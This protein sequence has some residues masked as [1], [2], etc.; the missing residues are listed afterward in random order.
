MEVLK[1]I[2]S[3]LIFVSIILNMFNIAIAE[4]EVPLYIDD[5]LMEDSLKPLL[6]DGR[7]I[8]PLR[9]ITEF[10]GGE[11]D[12]DNTTKTVTINSNDNL[13]KLTINSSTIVKNG[14][15]IVL[16]ATPKLV[17]SRTFVPLRFIAELLDCQVHWDKEIESVKIM[18]PVENPSDNPT[19]KKA[20]LIE[21]SK[22]RRADDYA[23][24]LDISKDIKY[25]TTTLSNPA[26]YVIDLID[27]EFAI[28]NSKLDN[29]GVFT[30]DNFGG[31]YIK[32]V[33]ASQFETNPLTSRVVLDLTG[34][35]GYPHIKWIDENLVVYYTN[36]LN[37]DE[38]VLPENP[39]ENQPPEETDKGE[40][41]EGKDL[42][43]GL[44]N[45]PIM[46]NTAKSINYF[47]EGIVEEEEDIFGYISGNRVNVRNESSTDKDSSIVATLDRGTK[48]RVTGQASGWY[49]VSY[50]NQGVWV[51]DKYFSVEI[52]MKRNNVNVRKGPSINYQVVETIPSGS[53]V[54]VSERQPDWVKVTTEN[55]NE[56]YIVDYLV[57]LNERLL[58]G[59][60][61]G[62][63]VAKEFRI[64]LEDI[65]KED[66]S[67]SKL[68]K[69]VN[70]SKIS[71]QGKDTIVEISLDQPI[72]YRHQKVAGGI[73]LDL[74][75]ILEDIKVTESSGKVVVDM[76]FDAPTKFIIYQNQLKGNLVLDFLYASAKNEQSYNLEG[77]IASK[78]TTINKVD[79][80][81]VST[82]LGDIGTYKLN[83]T[84]Y[85][86]HVR[87]EL[88]SSSLD[89][90]VIVLDPGHGGRDPGA[91]YVGYKESDI[92]LEISLK[93]RDKLRAKG[94]TVLMTRDT[95]KYV[96]LGERTNY[97][98][99]M[100]ADIAISVHINSTIS[101]A[102]SGVET[103]YYDK[104]EDKRLARVLQGA[105]VSSTG[106]PNRGI[107]NRQKIFF[108]KNTLMPSALLEIG[109]IRNPSDR[110][111]ITSN[112]GQE[113]ITNHIVAAIES[114]FL[115]Q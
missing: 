90:K 32:S 16:D 82:T 34:K 63:N 8:A 1:K 70:Q 6:K 81:E 65:E 46:L 40:E 66:V 60:N 52:I 58:D 107:V 101:S 33:R 97:A 114:F 110:A 53:L 106:F 3:M 112:A 39:D 18:T 79:S 9:V 42:E 31:E 62:A 2:F 75:S 96:S 76:Y 91:N 94:V 99:E 44:T 24:F 28:D 93:I 87:L 41:E 12:W 47:V 29:S 73:Q 26:R 71:A 45:Y 104:P 61:Q 30:L 89:D 23:L 48:L 11:V 95:D 69:I 50:N 84:G 17:E 100:N 57:G 13:A 49:Q 102:V 21:V 98:N 22:M 83:T 92:A 19:N 5:K 68:P 38:I 36:D 59:V 85:S 64:T 37:G 7:T 56:G 109:F 67:L 25:K 115:Y 55:G 74:G 4:K 105:L 27:T 14:E 72:A 80:I 108:T 113:N 35:K 111:Y 43:I 15:S 77:S 103:I 20:S 78:V 86:K 88:L 10:L 51:S 54:T